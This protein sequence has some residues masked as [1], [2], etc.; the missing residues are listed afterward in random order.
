MICQYWTNVTQ[1]EPR[2][3]LWSLCLI[4][5]FESV[6]LV[7]FLLCLGNTHSL[8]VLE[9]SAVGRLPLWAVSTY[10]RWDLHTFEL[11]L[12]RSVFTS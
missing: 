6:S 3:L 11:S 7:P 9:D 8:S 4:L 2:A 1:D 12:E 5:G 10:G